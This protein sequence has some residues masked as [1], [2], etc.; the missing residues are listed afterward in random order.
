MGLE[1]SVL[2]II[3]GLKIREE[4][5][6][7]RQMPWKQ[8][9]TNDRS[10]ESK[11]KLNSD[12]LAMWK[13]PKTV[14]DVSDIFN[15]FLNGSVKK[16][17]WCQEGPSP[18]TNFL[19]K[20]LKT[21]NTFGLLTINSQPRCNGALS[22][23]PYVGWGPADGFVYQKSYV[24]CFCSKEN[25]EKLLSAFDREKMKF[26]SYTAVNQNNDVKSNVAENSVN[27]VT[28]G[29]FP[30]QEIIQP[31]VVD[32]TS[33]MAWKDEAFGLWNDWIDCSDDENSKTLLRSIKDNWYLMSIV[34]N[35]FVRGDLCNN[36]IDILKP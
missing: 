6:P 22:T 19:L 35:D 17:P 25:L 28:W 1:S 30:G 29:V 3:D 18:E 34:D 14:A 4:H 21:M 2:R 11:T 15:G 24:E 36:L 26:L 23:D 32:R 33:F 10:K 12:R 16:L 31:T 8:A 7:G 9:V 13:A 27:A 20:Q 5:K